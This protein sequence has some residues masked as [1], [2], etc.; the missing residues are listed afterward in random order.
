MRERVCVCVC[1]YK[2]YCCCCMHYMLDVIYVCTTSTVRT[3]IELFV[4][5][6]K[7]LYVY[8]FTISQKNLIQAMGP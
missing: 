4:D 5:D 1:R 3:K 6:L 7:M 2:V 8:V